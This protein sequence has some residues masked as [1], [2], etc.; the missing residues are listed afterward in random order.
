MSEHDERAIV[1]LT[2]AYC[3]ALDTKDFEALRDVFVP[4][5]TARY[6][7]DEL[8]SLDAVVATCARVLAP[9]DL[10]QHL[11]TNHEVR[12]DGDRAMCRCYFHAQHVRRAAEGG[13]NFVVAGRYDDELERTS[14]GWRILRRVL[15]TM[16]TEGNLGVVRPG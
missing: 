9:L 5:A 4:G 3:W 2:V 6:A 15:T 8:D 16:W 1:A 13:P 11:V 12:V 10:S 7:G 14:E